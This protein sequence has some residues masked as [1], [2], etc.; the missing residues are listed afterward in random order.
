MKI[1]IY[2]N[3]GISE[4]YNSP[5]FHLF[6]KEISSRH[7]VRSSFKKISKKEFN[8]FTEATKTITNIIKKHNLSSYGLILDASTINLDFIHEILAAK[9]C[10]L[11]GEV[12][13]KQ[14]NIL[15]KLPIIKHGG[16]FKKVSKSEH[17]TLSLC[18]HDALPS[19]YESFIEKDIY[20]DNLH[21]I[22][23]HE[24]I[25]HAMMSDMF[26]DI[27]VKLSYYIPTP[28][29]YEFLIKNSA[30]L[31]SPIT[32]SLE[33][34]FSN[35]L[36]M[37]TYI[38]TDQLAD[39]IHYLSEINSNEPDNINDDSIIN[40]V[41]YKPSYLFKDLVERFE[42]RGCIHSDFPLK[43]ASSYIWMRP[44]EIWHLEYLERGID[45]PEISKSYKSSYDSMKSELP[46]HEDIIKKS[47]AIHHGTCFEPLY[48]FNYNNL[49]KSLSSI[50][51]VI[52]VCEIEECYGPSYSIANKNNFTFI[53][54]GYDNNVFT[55]NF[56]KTSEKPAKSKLNIGFVG[57]A[58]GT[59]N[60]DLLKK[61]SLAEPK[62]YRKGGDLCL[63]ISLR[64]KAI[65][66]DFEL[67][68][69]GQ[70]WEELTDQLDAY[71]I[72]YKYYA[73]DR[74]ITYTDYPKVYSDMDILLISARCE[75][76]PVSAIEA[77]SLG[78][79]VVS[80]DV[81]VVKFLE[82]KLSASKGCA[83][84]QYDKKWHIADTE[85]AVKHIN[86]IY[87]RKI[88]KEDREEIRSAV[89]NY[90]T[91]HW[92]LSIFNMAKDL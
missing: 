32:R 16:I 89:Q 39:K 31:I 9:F 90:T 22:T 14:K 88:F 34:D 84:F 66:I 17:C 6:S 82:K 36:A 80:T 21:V 87:H 43:N 29:I 37:E 19:I 72:G 68:I 64:L 63:D 42:K 35:N 85:A 55:S 73:R 59:T 20:T 78:I 50:K 5:L 56:W 54:I 65:G 86:D 38:S 4:K 8:I 76:G 62:G 27:G 71:G 23:T 44:Q 13:I 1:S 15:E 91:D 61:S 79:N 47:I 46:T 7:N 58:Y 40:I 41:C 51:H 30:N 81:G 52:G 67:H 12:N 49:A 45:N 92:V 70:N 10:I 26:S 33:I 75:G 18:E 53:P 3:N 24:K 28:A 77:L 11:L 48:Q 83:T 2:I 69:L 57:R 25:N 60:K 74:N